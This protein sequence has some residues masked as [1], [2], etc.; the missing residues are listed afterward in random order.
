MLDFKMADCIKQK[1]FFQIYPNVC[2]E[3]IGCHLYTNKILN[4]YEC[5]GEIIFNMNS[6]PVTYIN[7]FV[8]HLQV[9]NDLLKNALSMFESKGKKKNI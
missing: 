1:N 7:N 6:V 5:N 8:K 4:D 3:K 9:Q 2:L